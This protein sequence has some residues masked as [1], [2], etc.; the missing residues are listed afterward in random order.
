M[1]YP[2]GVQIMKLTGHYR[3]KE[4]F[5][6]PHPVCSETSWNAVILFRR[7]GNPILMI[8]FKEGRMFVFLLL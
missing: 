7:T 3:D 4:I 1:N 8:S 5:S 2:A 6:S